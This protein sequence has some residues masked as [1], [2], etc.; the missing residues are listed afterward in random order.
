M[1]SISP[2]SWRAKAR[3]A[4]GST[5]KV[6]FSAVCSEVNGNAT[7]SAVN[8]EL[9]HMAMRQGRKAFMG[10]PFPLYLLIITKKEPWL[11]GARG[12]RPLFIIKYTIPMDSVV[13]QSWLAGWLAG[14]LGP[15]ASESEEEDRSIECSRDIIEAEK[16]PVDPSIDR[17]P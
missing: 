17:A 1:I 8:S 7:V 16:Q 13:V 10:R 2:L 14:W 5:S 11:V 15:G 6:A 4:S 3:R 12:P 9:T